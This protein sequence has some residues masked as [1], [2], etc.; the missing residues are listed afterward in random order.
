MT[1]QRPNKYW[2]VMWKYVS[3]LAMVVI[4]V[5][6]VYGIAVNGISYKAWSSVT[7]SVYIWLPRTVWVLST[8]CACINDYLCPYFIIHWNQKFN[9][10]ILLKGLCYNDK[11]NHPNIFRD[12]SLF[13]GMSLYLPVPLY[14]YRDLRWSYSGLCGHTYSS[15]SWCS[16]L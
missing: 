12:I 10:I 7:V 2:L 11:N 13:T 5:A 3:P 8:N 6:S 14:I 1:G 15:H 9:E 4:L 16:I